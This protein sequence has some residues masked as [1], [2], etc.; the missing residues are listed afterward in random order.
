MRFMRLAFSMHADAP[1]P[2]AS[3][4]LPPRFHA[5]VVRSCAANHGAVVAAGDKIGEKADSTKKSL[6]SAAA[7]ATVVKDDAATK[8]QEGLEKVKS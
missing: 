6:D 8:A 5:E 3:A 7:Q 1:L 4:V 2:V